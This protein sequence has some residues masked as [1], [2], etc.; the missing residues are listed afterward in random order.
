MIR[1][2]IFAGPL[3]D[4]SQFTRLAWLDVAY[5]K[6]APYASY[7]TCL[8]QNGRGAG[9]T[10]VIMDYPRWSSSL[11]DLLARAIC[12][13]LNNQRLVE[14]DKESIP[15]PLVDKPN[16]AFAEE[17]SV[18]VEHHSGGKVTRI[19]TLC[20]MSVLKGKRKGSYV[21]S[22]TDN[23]GK[24]YEGIEVVYRP[25]I[26]EPALLVAMVACKHLHGDSASLPPR[27]LLVLPSA[28]EEQGY[29][30]VCVNAVREP[31]KSGFLRWLAE[32]KEPIIHSDAYGEVVNADLYARFLME[33][34]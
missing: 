30:W 6:V 24:S 10:S 19:R 26:F 27:P 34:L 22:L 13:H 31:A 3:S 18:R 12:I 1:L 9:P 8:F 4:A 20:T 15:P 14:D 28:Q 11:W 5:L 21:A 33:S 23:L 32:S 17:L 29:K 2:S 7:K 16:L 25:S